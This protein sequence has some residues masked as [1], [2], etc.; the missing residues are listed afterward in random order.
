MWALVSTCAIVREQMKREG[1]EK[2]GSDEE[3]NVDPPMHS[4]RIGIGFSGIHVL[5]LRRA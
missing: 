4:G 1:H 5:I 2:D 3:C